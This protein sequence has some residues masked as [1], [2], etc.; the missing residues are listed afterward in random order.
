MDPTEEPLEPFGADPPWQEEVDFPPRRRK[1]GAWIVVSMLSLSL[2]LVG[3]AAE[4]RYHVVALVKERLADKP[5]E[6]AQPRLTPAAPGADP[7]VTF[8][9]SDGEQALAQGRLEA[10]QGAFDKASVL[11]DH[12][13]RV[14]LDEARVA[15]TKAEVPWLEL[16]LLPASATEET[17]VAKAQLDDLVGAARQASDDALA[18]APHDPAASLAKLD[19]LRLAGDTTGARAYI[20]ALTGPTGQASPTDTAYSLAALDLPASSPPTA[21]T[22]ERLRAAANDTA[23]EPKARAALV[24]ALNRAGDA[25]GAK[26]ELAKLDALPRPY[27]LSPNLHAW[28]GLDATAAAPAAAPPVDSAAAP[29]APPAGVAAPQPV[30]VPPPAVSQLAQAAASGADTGVQ[31]AQEAVRRGDYDRAERI[32]QALVNQHP[33]D[34]QMLT[35]LG[36]VRRVHNDPW[37]AIDVYQRAIEINPSYLPAQMGLADTQWARGD[38]DSAAKNYKH[39]V[40]RF[41]ASMYPD[42]VPQRAAP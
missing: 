9:L 17:R 15:N 28:L 11:T 35:A 25:A 22:V 36:N 7:R 13:P 16:R 32:Y 42:Y 26:A 27:P 4:K 29:P 34:S 19:A 39:I 30:A 1:L 37:G 3:W 23:D 40:D 20:A 38:R 33:R 24:Y 18:A 6:V 31:A 10:A 12:D 21:A 2:G 14:L 5:S 41:P 8:L